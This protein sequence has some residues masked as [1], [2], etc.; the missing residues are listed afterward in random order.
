MISRK[1]KAAIGALIVAAGTAAAVAPAEAQ[2]YRRHYHRDNGAAIGAGIAL[3]IIGLGAAAIAADQRRQAYENSYYAPRYG[4]GYGG[5][6]Y[7]PRARYYSE[8]PYVYERPVVR[9]RRGPAVDERYPHT[10]RHY[11]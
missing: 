4:Y 3:G 7:A 6:Y 2:Y 8:P 1:A 9:Y 11:R 10:F 5:G